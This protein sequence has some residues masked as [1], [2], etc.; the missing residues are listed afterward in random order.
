MVLA[1]AHLFVSMS[2][3][4]E[5]QLVEVASAGFALS[6]CLALFYFRSALPA[7]LS[8]DDSGIG[9]HACTVVFVCWAGGCPTPDTNTVTVFSA[10]AADG[11]RGGGE[12]LVDALPQIRRFFSVFELVLTACVRIGFDGCASI[13]P[14]GGA[15]GGSADGGSFC[16]ACS[17]CL[18]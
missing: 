4:E 5:A 12:D 15:G 14:H 8:S 9:G 13:C 18:S 6:I 16:W 3:L 7:V 10:L 11:G 1:T 2:A 17:I